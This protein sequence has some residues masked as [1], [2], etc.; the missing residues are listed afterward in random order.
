MK[1]KARFLLVTLFV[2]IL[3]AVVYIS[4]FGMAFAIG[5]GGGKVPFVLQAALA[6]LGG[7]LMFLMYLPPS[8]FEFFGNRWWGDDSVFLIGL[9]VL[10]ALLWGAGIAW[11]LQ[12]RRRRQLAGEL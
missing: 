5:D 1:T 12:G 11:L 6:V 10:N 3:H 8:Y 2:A 4:L 9:A 7:P